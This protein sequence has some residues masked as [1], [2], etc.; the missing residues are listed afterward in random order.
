[1]RKV[2]VAWGRSLHCMRKVTGLHEEDHYTAWG[3][4]LHCMRKVTGLHEEDH[5]TAWG[6]SLGFMLPATGYSF[7]FLLFKIFV[8]VV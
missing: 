8:Q 5:C 6:R 1:M 7:F 2:T 4:S 3:R